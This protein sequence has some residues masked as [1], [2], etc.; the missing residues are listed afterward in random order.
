MMQ[1][2]NL[3]RNVSHLM[4]TKKM[5][6]VI[7]SLW[8]HYHQNDNIQYNDNKHNGTEYDET[9]HHETECNET[10]QYDTENGNTQHDNTLL[11]A[12]CHMA[13]LH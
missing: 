3:C 5:I 1:C 2:L 6:Q 10:Q 11:N 13:V 7:K 8:H 12:K 9:Q 4:P